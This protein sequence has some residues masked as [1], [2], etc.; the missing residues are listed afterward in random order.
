M[1]TRPYA[2]LT[3][4]I[5]AMA[6]ALATTTAAMGSSPVIPMP[7]EKFL[8]DAER[9][10]VAR[11]MSPNERRVIGPLLEGDGGLVVAY[12]RR[13]YRV[14]T[15]PDGLPHPELVAP[16]VSQPGSAMSLPNEAVASTA[17]KPGTDLYVSFSIVRTRTSPPY[18]WQVAPY[19]EWRGTDGM[20][21]GNGSA[22]TMAVAWAGSTTYLYSQKGNGQQTKGW[23]CNGSPIDIWPSDGTPGAGT[24]WS[25]HE[26]GYWWGCHAWWGWADI[27]LRENSWQY[28]TD[29]LVYR[30]FHT[31]GGLTYSFSFSKSPGVTISPTSEQWSLAVFETYRH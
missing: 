28:R 27:R 25:F 18:E 29:N 3:A 5:L 24:A 17:T 19:F 9:A 21:R 6:A 23:P 7:G 4:L 14:V 12:S 30:Y 20:N 2:I 16:V 26:W 15:G 10:L 31:Y 1:H 11:T 22:D 8:T 13:L